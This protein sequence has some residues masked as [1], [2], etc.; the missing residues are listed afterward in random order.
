MHN[1]E[2]AHNVSIWYPTMNPVLE[3]ADVRSS[4]KTIAMENFHVQAKVRGCIELISL[5]NDNNEL[6]NRLSLYP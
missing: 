3:C 1:S 4:Y 6:N 2:H 5:G